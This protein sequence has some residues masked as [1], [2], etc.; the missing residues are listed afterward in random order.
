MLYLL[1][2]ISASL[3][4]FEQQDTVQGDILKSDVMHILGHLQTGLGWLS[5]AENFQCAKDAWQMKIQV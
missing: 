3:L 5:G 2:K 4:L 1:N